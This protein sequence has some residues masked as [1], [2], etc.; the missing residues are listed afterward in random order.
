[1]REMHR[2]NT[3]PVVYLWDRQTKQ[4]SVR[5]DFKVPTPSKK[6]MQVVTDVFPSAKSGLYAAKECQELF[7]TDRRSVTEQQFQIFRPALSHYPEIAVTI[8]EEKLGNMGRPNIIGVFRVTELL[9]SP[10]G[11]K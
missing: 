8:T 4:P 6:V 2:I 11:Y 9:H 3:V 7:M 10:P 1:M 5:I